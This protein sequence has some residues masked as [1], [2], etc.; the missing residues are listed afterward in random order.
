MFDQGDAE[1]IDNWQKMHSIDELKEIVIRKGYSAFVVSTDGDFLTAHLKW[2]PYQLTKE[3]C[4]PSPHK[5]TFYI[6]DAGAGSACES[7][8]GGSPDNPVPLKPTP[9]EVQYWLDGGKAETEGN[10]QHR[11]AAIAA[12]WVVE[13]AKVA[14]YNHEVK[15]KL[16][17]LL[18]CSNFTLHLAIYQPLARGSVWSSILQNGLDKELAK[19]AAKMAAVNDSENIKI[20]LGIEAI[21]PMVTHNTIYPAG[22]PRTTVRQDR[23]MPILA[24]QLDYSD[25]KSRPEEIFIHLQLLLASA[26]DP[27]FGE[28][29]DV[30]VSDLKVEQDFA[31]D[32]GGD[33]IAE[34][35]GDAA[36]T[37]AVHTAPFKTFSR[38]IGKM[39][40]AEDHR[41]ETKPRPGLNIDVVRRLVE[42]STP[43]I[44]RMFVKELTKSAKASYIKCLPDTAGSCEAAARYQVLPVM[45]TVAFDAGG[46]TIGIYWSYLGRRRLGPSCDQLPKDVCTGSSG[47]EITT[48]LLQF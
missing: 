2:F 4:K 28:F 1:T 35:D 42:V 44:A 15:M 27:L 34:A 19:L 45:V 18:A 13:A 31:G 32:S 22:T 29:L 23:A 20:E 16:R 25:W 46:R 47:L 6:Y 36:S 48:E 33:G 10:L 14:P 12:Y 43:W 3:H 7:S 30:L 11:Q 9:L 39:V 40:S 17:Q 5:L 21:R 8:R 24:G 38:M 26:I 37:I 41:Y